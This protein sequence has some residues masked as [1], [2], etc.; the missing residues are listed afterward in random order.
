MENQTEKESG[1]KVKTY[2]KNLP[3]RYFIDA[4]T[5][6]AQGL[7]VTLIAGTIVKTIGSL[8]G[9]N[10][11]GRIFVLIGQAAS[12]LMGAGIGA[13]IANYLKAPKLVVFS[14]IVAGFMGAFAEQILGAAV[15]Y[16]S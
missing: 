7:F 14:A 10:A 9:D 1:S 2:F 8:I 4:F 11:V 13:G 15:T 3:K 5:G 16:N 6:M 12:V